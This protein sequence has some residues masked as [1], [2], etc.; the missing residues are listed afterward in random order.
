MEEFNEQ[1]FLNRLSSA[2][3]AVRRILENTRNPTLPSNVAHTYLDKFLLVEF[4]LNTTCASFVNA[5]EPLGLSEKN[6]ATLK[7]WSTS[8]SVSLRFSSEETCKFLHKRERVNKQSSSVSDLISPRGFVNRFVTKSVITKVME[9]THQI[10]V[11]YTLAAFCGNKPDEP[12]IL[13]K[14]TGTTTITSTNEDPPA[15][16]FKVYGPLDVNITWLLQ[17]LDDS[18]NLSIIINRENEKCY[19]PRR[20]PEV[21]TGFEFLVSL[22]KWAEKVKE[23]FM[24]HLRSLSSESIS[25]ISTFGIFVPVIP[26]FDTTIDRDNIGSIPNNKK[27]K[28]LVSVISSEDCKESKVILS[29]LDVHNFLAEQIRTLNSSLKDT[30]ST[31]SRKSL[32]S[33]DGAQISLCVSHIMDICSAFGDGVDFVEE[34]L[35]KQ[36]IK[37]I[38]K[39]LMPRDFDEYMRY[40]YRKIFKEEFEPTAFCYSIR[41]PDHYPEGVLSIESAP[42][43]QETSEPINTISR[44]LNGCGDMKFAINAATKITFGGERYIHA[45][46]SSEFSNSTPTPLNIVARARQFSSF[47]LLIGNILSANEFQPKHAIIIQNKDDLLIPLLTEVIPT[48]KA[49]KKAVES[50]SEEQRAFAKAYRGMQL[51]STLFGMCIIQI[52]PQLEKLLRIPN[53]SLT[54]EIKMTQKLMELF[55]EYQIPSDLLAYQFEEGINHTDEQRIQFVKEQVQVMKD[56]IS[57]KQE[58]E[59]KQVEQEKKLELYDLGIYS[60]SDGSEESDGSI[61]LEC[62]ELDCIPKYSM[63]SNDLLC[64]DFDDFAYECPPPMM[65]CYSAAPMMEMA[66]DCAAP[67]KKSKSRNSSKDKKVAKKKVKDEKPKESVAKPQLKREESK[68]DKSEVESKADEPVE[69]KQ[70]EAKPEGPKEPENKDEPKEKEDKPKEK[71]ENLEEESLLDFTKLPEILDRNFELLDTDSALHSTILT[72]GESWTKNYQKA[73]LATPSTLTLSIEDQEKERNKA[74]DLLDALSRSGSLPIDCATFHVV[75]AATHCFDRTLLNTVVQD[76]VNPIEKVERSALIV[77]TTI[78]EESPEAMIQES[79]KEKIKKASPHLFSE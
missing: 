42:S 8:R 29:D 54:K 62:E 33:S 65:E 74:F 44:K 11:S 13:T 63:A 57:G 52:K 26:L 69:I 19:T 55:I 76:C 34:M 16:D 9:Y 15:P 31:Y 3:E 67:M 20:N 2:S 10:D 5:L 12:I 37:A 38:G 79:V 68:A 64:A 7:E 17:Q 53:D 30:K 49:F 41:R 78:H 47:I 25:S 77:S 70:E 21:D 66:L 39:E 28:K 6:L 61:G 48:P 4:L 75:V 73:L 60:S 36:L 14:G 35:R 59:I 46:I 24:S 72:V 22:H 51:E 23:Y 27:S 40:H 50:L 45:W 32:V 1:V 56:M 43:E 18:F 71:E 58:E